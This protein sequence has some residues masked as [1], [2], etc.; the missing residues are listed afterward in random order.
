[1][2]SMDRRRFLVGA[3]GAGFIVATGPLAGAAAAAQRTA[4]RTRVYVIVVD[5]CSPGEITPTLMPN[6]SALRDAGTNFPAAQ[7]LPVMETIPNH[8]MM[9]SGV[10]PDRSG[11]PANTVYDRAEGA[12]RTLDR[13]TDLGVPTLL[14]RLRDLGLTTGSVLSKQYLFGIFGQ[15]ATYRWEPMPIVPV[16]G[17]APDPF[18]ADALIAMVNEV[19]PDLVFANFG[20]IDRYGHSDYTGPLSV[21][22]LRTAA[23]AGEDVQIGRFLDRLKATGRWSSSVVLVLADH[24]MDW[25]LPTGFIT[26]DAVLRADPLLVGKYVI[27]QNGGAELISWTGPDADRTAGI[28]R[29]RQLAQLQTGVLS[30]H[31]PAE[32]RLGARAGDV[33]CY[34]RA[35]FR[36]SDTTPVSNPLPGNHGHPATLPIP[37]FV[38]GGSPL[39]SPGRTSSSAARTID[40]APTVGS[41]FG[42][43]AP[44]GGYD[45]TAR[46]EAFRTKGAKRPR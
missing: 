16:S 5:G 17:H 27:A 33:L 45:G 46:T 13:P 12:V 37:F 15:R 44:P 1:M 30:V 39:V 4:T 18:T 22:A 42:L 8:V 21:D 20:D 11:V 29:I 9:M 24:S 2:T 41:L 35:G 19:D 25:S 7:S 10:R 26:L 31:D 3:A 38:G 36:F 34:A 28:A 23:L 43:S 32:F 6:L 40:V 14:D